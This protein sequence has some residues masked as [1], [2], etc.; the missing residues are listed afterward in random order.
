MEEQITFFLQANNNPDVSALTV[1]DMLKAFMR[2][3]ILSFT[4]NMKKKKKTRNWNNCDQTSYLKSATLTKN[5]RNT[6]PQSY[7]TKK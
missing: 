1:W 4:A 3:Q 7:T 6:K 5:M 2:G